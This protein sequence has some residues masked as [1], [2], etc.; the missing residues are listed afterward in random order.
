M[1]ISAIARSAPQKND[2]IVD[3]KISE[4]R[5]GYILRLEN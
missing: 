3:E 2:L 1:L 5:P 4:Q